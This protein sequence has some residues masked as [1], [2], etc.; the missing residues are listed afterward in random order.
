[1]IEFILIRHGETDW[2]KEKRYQGKTDVPLSTEGKKQV[3]CLSRVFAQYEPHVVY[4]STLSRTRESGTILCKSIAAPLKEDAQLNELNFG[5][6]E[7]KTADELIKTQD[8]LYTKW[9]EGQLIKPPHGETVSS[10]RKRVKNFLQECIKTH[11]NKTVAIVSHGGVLRLLIIEILG[12]PQK[13]LFTFKVE[14]G[15]M[16]VLTLAEGFG[17]LLL[18]N[19]IPSQK[20]AK[21]IG[22]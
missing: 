16:S 2:S 3:R 18:F 17:Q 1:M 22:C 10:L 11:K 19:A 13:N 7:G 9:M 20:G 21:A 8:P 14:T 6:W 12:L 15:T 5:E 4:T